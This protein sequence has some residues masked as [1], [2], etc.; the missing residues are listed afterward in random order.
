MLDEAFQI[1]KSSAS[2]KPNSGD[3]CESFGHFIANKLRNYSVTTRNAVQ[4]S[5]C[6][7]I[8]SADQGQF[9]IYYYPNLYVQAPML[10]TT[11]NHNQK[12]YNFHYSNST[13]PSSIINTSA[14]TRSSY[15]P[16]TATLISSQDTTS[17]LYVS[18]DHTPS[19][20][21][22]LS[23]VTYSSNTPCDEDSNAGI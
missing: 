1:L 8:F 19:P 11:M 7:N 13:L 12:L 9:D 15:I 4:Q 10:A 6:N 5:I 21:P 14:S 2:N 22:T 16:Q 18:S 23:H 20:V 17:T 3:E